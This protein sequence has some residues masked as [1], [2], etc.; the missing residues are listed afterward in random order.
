M[1][2]CGKPTINGELGFRWNNPDAKP[3][4]YPL[5]AP[6]LNEG[7]TLLYDEPGRC[8]GLDCHSHH[9]RLVRIYGSIYLYVRHGGGDERFRLSTTPSFLAG[10]A[11]MDSTMRYW[12]FHSIYYAHHY[13]VQ[14]ARDAERSRWQQAAADKRIKTRKQ[15]GSNTVKVWI[16]EKLSNAS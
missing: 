13:A 3:G 10:L 1:C 8:G 15:R 6:K 12:T 14:E 16:E 9:Y 2:C 4:I 11:A 5:N 7:D